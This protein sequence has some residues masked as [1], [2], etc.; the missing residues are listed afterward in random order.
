MLRKCKVCGAEAHTEEELELFV[1]ARDNKYGRKQLC[2]DCRA[3]GIR[4]A[5][6]QQQDFVPKA[7]YIYIITNPAWEGWC[8]VGMTSVSIERRLND[9]QTQ[10]PFRDFECVYHKPVD[11]VGDTEK[12]I[13]RVLRGICEYN[14]EW[15][16]IKINECIEKI[17][18]VTN[19]RS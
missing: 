7:G 4:K 6:R 10:S 3:E 8:K 15:F 13:H 1:I 18:E 17:E 2:K 12:D 5:K 19:D 11:D 9:Y 16:K 14:S